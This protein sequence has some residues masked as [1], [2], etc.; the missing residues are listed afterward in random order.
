MRGAKQPKG[1]P[2]RKN[3]LRAVPPTGAMTSGTG[4][5]IVVASGGATTT[6]S[7]FTLGAPVTA[8]LYQYQL[9]R[10]PD[11]GGTPDAQNSWYLRSHL[12]GPGPTPIPIYRPEG[13]M[14]AAMP[15]LGRELTRGAIGTFHDYNGDQALMR[16]N[17]QGGRAGRAWSRVY[18]EAI[19]QG[20]AGVLSPNFKGRA[21]GFQTGVDLFES[22]TASGFNDRFGVFFGYAKADGD[23]RGF[24]L[25][26]QNNYVGDTSLEGLSGG[27]YWTRV[28]PSDGYLEARVLGTHYTGGGTSVANNINTKVKGTSI[29]A[30]LEAGQPFRFG[31]FT[32]EP[33]A[34]LIYQY[35]DMTGQ[36]PLSTVAYDT[37]DAFYARVGLR[38]SSDGIFGLSNVR[39]SG[40]MLSAPTRRS[41][42]TPMLS[43]PAFGRPHWRSAAAWWRS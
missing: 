13:A 42:P 1:I 33:Q 17:G 5:L 15:S 37:P 24:A 19:E 9:F 21:Y 14:F 31:N 43:I 11:A 4:I 27:A 18:G 30:S 23:V 41:S 40:R 22:E 38:L 39:L 32:I 10:G 26:I 16:G 8:G 12:V 34:Q 20:H 2:F 28:G 3:P 25:G 35:L 29:A 36:D 7:A 6:G